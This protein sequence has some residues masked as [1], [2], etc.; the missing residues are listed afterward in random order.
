MATTFIWVVLGLPLSLLI[1]N[2]EEAA[3]TG[4]VACLT[5][6]AIYLRQTPSPPLMAVHTASKGRI[7]AQC[8]KLSYPEQFLRIETWPFALEPLCIRFFASGEASPWPTTHTDLQ[9]SLRYPLRPPWKLTSDTISGAFYLH[10][11]L[12]VQAI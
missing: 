5:A 7:A 8:R 3:S 11:K 6:T 4:R 1:F 9:A 2:W 12:V 10:E